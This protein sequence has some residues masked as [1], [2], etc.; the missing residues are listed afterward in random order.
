M[1][2]D[3]NKHIVATVFS[4]MLHPLMMPLY[5]AII[6]LFVSPFSYTTVTANKYIY[7]SVIVCFFQLFPVLILWICYK[8]GIISEIQLNHRS[9]RFVPM[10]AVF[11]SFFIGFFI[12]Q[13]LTAPSTLIMLLRGVCV[14][15]LLVASVSIFW[16]ISAHTTGIGGAFAIILILSI[17]FQTD[18]SRVAIITAIYSG[19]LGWSR[20]YLNHHNKPQI[21]SGFIL[22]FCTVFVMFAINL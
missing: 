9:E 3:E 16:K 22:G 2:S 11:I 5:L 1:F 8:K 18:L 20:L 17:S 21:Y 10:V 13:K 6:F 7:L 14:A 12:L 4:K 15:V 19:I